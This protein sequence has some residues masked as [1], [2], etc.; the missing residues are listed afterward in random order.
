MGK[1][2]NFSRRGQAKSN[3]I[4]KE[5]IRVLLAFGRDI[6]CGN[7]PHEVFYHTKIIAIPQLLNYQ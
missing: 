2:G 3:K 5:R 1:L 4:I 7:G 6:V